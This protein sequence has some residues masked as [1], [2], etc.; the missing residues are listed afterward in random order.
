MWSI[1]KFSK[2]NQCIFADCHGRNRRQTF[3]CYF[4]SS[5][6]INNITERDSGKWKI[7]ANFAWKIKEKMTRTSCK[8]TKSVNYLVQTVAVLWMQ[9][10][11][12]LGTEIEVVPLENAKPIVSRTGKVNSFTDGVGKA[13][14]R[15]MTQTLTVHFS[16]ASKE[17]IFYL[18]VGQ[19][20]EREVIPTRREILTLMVTRWSEMGWWDSR[21]RPYYLMSLSSIG[22]VLMYPNSEI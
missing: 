11:E 20:D 8:K 22:L 6:Q 7:S 14:I 4:S 9:A 2:S 12:N 19:Q 15:R 3:R 21:Q 10:V 5:S 17:L 13:A 16:P 1:T 18:I